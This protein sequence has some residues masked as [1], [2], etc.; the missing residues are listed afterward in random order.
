MYL[1]YGSRCFIRVTDINVT[2]SPCRWC[3][4]ITLIIVSYDKVCT[5][6]HFILLGLLKTKENVGYKVLD[7]VSRSETVNRL[8]LLFPLSS[9][10]HIFFFMFGGFTFHFDTSINN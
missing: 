1:G 7:K 4:T 10:I 6:I 3:C 2:G 5:G 8:S 9:A